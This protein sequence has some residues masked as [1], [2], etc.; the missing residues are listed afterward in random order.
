MSVPFATPRAGQR[1]KQQA[2][3]CGA[4]PSEKETG[5]E[6]GDAVRVSQYRVPYLDETCLGVEG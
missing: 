2:V 4:E 3:Q 1:D 5:S 6:T